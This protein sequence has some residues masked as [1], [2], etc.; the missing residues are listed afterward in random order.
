MHSISGFLRYTVRLGVAGLVV[1]AAACDNSV[2]PAPPVV[3]SLAITAART[4][5]CQADTVRIQATAKEASGTTIPR[6]KI[7]W[8]SSQTSVA[9]VDTTGLVK[10]V[11]GGITAVRA[12]SGTITAEIELKVRA[13]LVTFAYKYPSLFVND[14]TLVVATVID[15]NGVA[16]PEPA[17]SLI[18]RSTSIATVATNGVVTA[19]AA[20]VVDIAARGACGAEGVVQVAVLAP[21]VRAPREISFIQDKVA[22]FGS[23][24]VLM[25]PDGS[26]KR[27][28]S[29][30]DDAVG[31]HIWSPDGNRLIVALSTANNPTRAGYFIINADGSGEIPLGTFLNAPDWSPDG[32]RVAYRNYI[33]YGESD[34]YTLKTDG[35]DVRRLSSAA[36]D[37]LNPKWSPDGRQLLY[38]H[39]VAGG[40]DLYVVAADSS[41]RRK[42]SVPIPSVR[43]PRWTADG[44]GIVMDN[45]T[46]IFLVNA[47]GTRFRSLTSNCTAAG[48][49]SGVFSYSNPTVDPTGA[50][51]AFASANWGVGYALVNGGGSDVLTIGNGPRGLPSAISWSPDGLSTV[52]YTHDGLFGGTYGI[53][54]IG[55]SGLRFVVK[56]G[57]PIF[58][59]GNPTFR[60]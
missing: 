42:I 53:A 36:G 32:A 41:D 30:R 38:F 4:L 10:A 47:D 20:G 29:A 51:V 43:N 22:G 33:A 12:T 45:G 11:G 49:C 34:I 35:T 19:K 39:P 18:S 25:N 7:T 50:R 31:E 21:R 26:N 27:V 9:T 44:K 57:A 13:P 23:E 37:D 40:Q 17:T 28:I 1:S 15:K 14:T 60:P 48:T 52:F 55:P 54:I 6:A 2:E 58:N 46:G 16:P 5:A 56:S 3:A 24:L 59:Y 8:T